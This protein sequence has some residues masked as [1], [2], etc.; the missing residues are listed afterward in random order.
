M[1]K[2][3]G[4]K[5]I[6]E[7]RKAYHN[8]SI[9]ET[10]ETGIA[11]SGTEVKSLRAGR[12]NLSDSYAQ[13]KNGELWLTGLHISPYEQ[14]NRFNKDPLRDRKLLAHKREILKWMGRVK[15]DG[16]TMVPTKLYFKHS[17]VKVELGLAKGKKNY[18]KRDA[19]IKRDSDRQIQQSLKRQRNEAQ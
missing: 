10:M 18:D 6:A 14:G 15:Q 13:V 9:L 1:A 8:Y 16:L 17:L 3:E 5:I 4:I 12:A 2:T 19:L 11:L 7:N